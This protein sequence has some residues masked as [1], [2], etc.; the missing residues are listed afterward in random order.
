MLT[1]AV[2]ALEFD[3]TYHQVS[4]VL[5]TVCVKAI[6]ENTII[7][8]CYSVIHKLFEYMWCMIVVH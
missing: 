4:I 2:K 6:H 7:L 1:C 8:L 5:C 3:F